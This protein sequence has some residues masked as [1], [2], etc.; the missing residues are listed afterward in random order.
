MNQGTKAV[1]MLCA[2][3][4]SNLRGIRKIR[5]REQFLFLASGDAD[6]LIADWVAD[7]ESDALAGISVAEFGD[8]VLLEKWLEWLGG[9][10]FK[11]F[12]DTIIPLIEKIFEIIAGIAL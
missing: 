5:K 12:V 3:A 11:N 8:G 7:H 10:G 4:A 2:A 1:K 9:D 6:V